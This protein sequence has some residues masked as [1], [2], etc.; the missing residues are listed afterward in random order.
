LEAALAIPTAML[1]AYYRGTLLDRTVIAICVAAMSI[2]F[3]V[4]II[5]GQYVFGFQLGWFPVQGWSD[6]FWRNLVTYAPL[7][8]LLAALVGLAPQ[9]R[10]YRSFFLDETKSDYVRTAR[11]KGLSERVVILKHAL[12]NALTPVITLGALGFGE[13]LGGTVLTESVFSIPGF[14]KLIVDAVFNRDYAVV[15]GVVLVTATTYIL[16]NLL[17]DLAYFLVNPRMRG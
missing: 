11:A 5:V 3:L 15:Q 6:S 8:I 17:A 7:P 1:V 14:G 10:L 16:L 12:R 4:Y 2:S 13:L 9:T